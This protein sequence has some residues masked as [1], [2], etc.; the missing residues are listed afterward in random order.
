MTAITK[1]IFNMPVT[2]KVAA[3]KRARTQGITLTEFLNAATKAF[4]KGDMDMSAPELRATPQAI[5]RAQKRRADA[6]VGKNL[7]PAFS[8]GKEVARWLKV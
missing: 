2:L 1:V 3:Q 7:T 5:R 8:S 4:V 6:R